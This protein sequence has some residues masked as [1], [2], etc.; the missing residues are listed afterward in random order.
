MATKSKTTKRELGNLPQGEHDLVSGRKANGAGNATKD[1]RLLT[2]KAAIKAEL[3]K[4][5]VANEK[6]HAKRMADC[7]EAADRLNRR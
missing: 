2:G 1:T 5:R 4:V 6:A 7:T 3:Q